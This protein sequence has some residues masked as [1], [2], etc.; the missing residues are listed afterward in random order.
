MFTVG[1]AKYN[2]RILL[3]GLCLAQLIMLFGCVTGSIPN[4]DQPECAESRDVVKKF[5]S[6]HFD[7]EMRFSKEN[8]R[9]KARFLTPEFLKSIEDLRTE[10]DLFTSDSTDFPR[11]FRLGAC[12]VIDS[13]KTL[14]E[15]LIFWRT[16][17]ESRQQS[18]MAEVI[19]QNDVWLINRITR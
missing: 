1:N 18:I 11:A 10:N 15:V 9:A 14:I 19:K 16:T 2:F 13:R 3:L 12:R 5:Y 7:G 17:D 6:I 4:L 8:L